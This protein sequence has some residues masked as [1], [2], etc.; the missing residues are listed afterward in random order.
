MFFLPVPAE[1]QRQNRFKFNQFLSQNRN[2]FQPK[3]ARFPASFI[4][5]FKPQ[6]WQKMTV[7]KHCDDG[8]KG[9]NGS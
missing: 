7:E 6:K 8:K 1:I 5:S 2:D 4:S 3:P 9:E